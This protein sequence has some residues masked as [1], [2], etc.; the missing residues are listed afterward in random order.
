MWVITKNCLDNKHMLKKS[1]FCNTDKCIYQ[2]R[3]LDAD[4]IV[5]FEGLSS[6]CDSEIAFHPLDFYGMPGYGCTDI[7]YKCDGI[8]VVL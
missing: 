7:E 8:W 1:P 3:L 5:Y 4:G 6:D 2:F